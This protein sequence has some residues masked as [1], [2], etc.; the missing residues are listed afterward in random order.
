M[1]SET[2]SQ[3]LRMSSQFHKA[4]GSSPVCLPGS[5]VTLQILQKFILFSRCSSVSFQMPQRYIHFFYQAGSPPKLPGFFHQ[6]APNPTYLSLHWPHLF[7]VFQCCSEISWQTVCKRQ[8]WHA[9]SGGRVWWQGRASGPY[10][11]AQWATLARA[12]PDRQYPAPEEINVVKE[13]R[14]RMMS[15]LPQTLLFCFWQV[16]WRFAVYCG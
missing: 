7:P 14:T 9:R 2:S 1:S 8:P 5:T 16:S 12:G 11:P 6:E 4:Q 10:T 15:V 3:L 13:K